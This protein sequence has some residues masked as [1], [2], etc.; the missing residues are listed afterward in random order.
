[1]SAVAPLRTKEERELGYAEAK[2][3]ARRAVIEEALRLMVRNTYQSLQDARRL[4]Q[5]AADNFGD[6]V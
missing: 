5:A 4:L 1:M 2:A 3:I 6:G